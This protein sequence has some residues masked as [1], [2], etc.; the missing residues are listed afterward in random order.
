[1]PMPMTFDLND[2]TQRCAFVALMR[3]EPEWIVLRKPVMSYC[4]RIPITNNNEEAF[5]ANE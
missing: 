2:P 4:A 1:M 5:Q 3:Q